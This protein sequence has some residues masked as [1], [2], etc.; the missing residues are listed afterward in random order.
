MFQFTG[1]VWRTETFQPAMA[2]GPRLDDGR[3]NA[4]GFGF[5]ISDFNLRSHARA[6]GRA[7]Q[8]PPVVYGAFLEQQDFKA[9]AAGGIRS[10][11]PGRDD[12]RVVQHQRVALRKVIEQ[13]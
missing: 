10:L 7:Q 2:F 9:P 12:A 13:V 3:R 11:E 5:W 8:G 1:N 4:S 6:F